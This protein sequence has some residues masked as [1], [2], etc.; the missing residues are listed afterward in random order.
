MGEKRTQGKKGQEYINEML[1][2]DKEIQD[3]HEQV[4]K[5]KQETT[6]DEGCTFAPD[7]STG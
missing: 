4:A 7:I 3:H 6:T 1:K 5:E 2:K